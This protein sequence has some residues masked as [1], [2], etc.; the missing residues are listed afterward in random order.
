MSDPFSGGNSEPTLTSGSIVVNNYVQ[1]NVKVLA[2]HEHEVDNVSFM[3]GLS[4]VCFSIMSALVGFSVSTWVNAAFQ[5]EW[6]PAARILSSVV[7]PG[8][9]I[10]AVLFLVAG[11]LA[12]DRKNSTLKTIKSQSISQQ[13]ISS[14]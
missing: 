13:Q 4:S 6:S 14:N 3:N 11:L 1:R 10:L 5:S 2:I 12:L 7:A 8:A 9:C